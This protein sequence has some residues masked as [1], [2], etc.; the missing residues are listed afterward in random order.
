MKNRRREGN[1]SPPIAEAFSR[2]GRLFTRNGNRID[3]RRIGTYAGAMAW[4]GDADGVKW[5]NASANGE[6][7]AFRRPDGKVYLR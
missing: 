1:I 5:K 3:H 7:R 6:A 4:T 2:G